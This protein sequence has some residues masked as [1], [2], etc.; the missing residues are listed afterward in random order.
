MKKIFLLLTASF[1]LSF[2][3]FAQ[4]DQAWT[5]PQCIEYAQTH[6]PGVLQTRTQIASQQILENSQQN[7]W[8]PVVSLQGGF[9]KSFATTSTQ[10]F[11]YPFAY[12]FAS[13]MLYDG[14]A[15]RANVKAVH[16]QI[17]ALEANLDKALQDLTVQVSTLFL[18]A[19]FLQTQADLLRRK[20]D[21]TLS[22]QNATRLQQEA[23]L[24][25]MVDQYTQVRLSLARLIGAP[26]PIAFHVAPME[27][28]ALSE[29]QLVVPDPAQTE[30]PLDQFPSIRAAQS[31]VQASE[32]SLK[33]AKSNYLPKLSWSIQTGSY[34]IDYYQR[35]DWNAIYGPFA[36]QAKEHFIFMP[37]VTLNLPVLNLV[38]TR[39]AVRQSRVMLDNSQQMLDVAQ[40]QVSAEACQAYTTTLAARAKYLALAAQTTDSTDVNLQYAMYDYLIKRSILDF[41]L[42]R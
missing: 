27:S 1:L 7:S 16:S 39:N 18:Q 19:Q 30:V 6:S 8:V 4:D 12:A 22:E 15:R 34:Y 37:A 10:R 20:T 26:D 13:G 40:K 3:A 5:L 42:S 17:D 41:Y 33:A 21:S 14:G 28:Q 31:Q 2:G 35:Q 24:A 32:Y 25:A 23:D 38:Q 9:Y 36:R 29:E 11:N